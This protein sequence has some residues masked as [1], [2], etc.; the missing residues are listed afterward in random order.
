[1]RSKSPACRVKRSR[2]SQSNSNKEQ[3]N[4]DVVIDTV[5]SR[6]QSP[7]S[8]EANDSSHSNHSS[9]P[10][11]GQSGFESLLVGLEDNGVKI[12]INDDKTDSN[13]NGTVV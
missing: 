13:F 8:P 12:H 10:A 3:P 2:S 5:E 9:P 7:D 1:M 11:S 6:V 4:I